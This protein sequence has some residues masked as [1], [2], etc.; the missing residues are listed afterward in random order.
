MSLICQPLIVKITRPQNLI[1]CQ[2]EP[3]GLRQ[4]RYG[5][6][7]DTDCAQLRHDAHEDQATWR[8][9]PVHMSQCAPGAFEHI[10]KWA[11]VGDDRVERTIRKARQITDVCQLSPHHR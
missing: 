9:H 1:E 2:R 5:L 4:R 10:A 8:E 11:S 7:E 6:P 3:M